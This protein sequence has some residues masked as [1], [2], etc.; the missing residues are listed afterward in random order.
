MLR[1]WLLLEKTGKGQYKKCLYNEKLQEC[2]L[3]ACLGV[4]CFTGILQD[5]KEENVKV[6]LQHL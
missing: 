1:V 4:F 2:L 6:F 3:K 5:G